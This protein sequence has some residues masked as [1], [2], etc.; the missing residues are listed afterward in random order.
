MVSTTLAATLIAASAF[1]EDKGAQKAP[2]MEMPK[3]PEQVAMAAKGMN[4]TWKCS[5]TMAASPMGPEH[6]YEATMT[7]KQSPDKYWL[8][9]NYAEKK[10]K[11][12]PMV[13]KFTEYRTFDAKMGKWVGAHIDEMGGMMTGTGTGDEKSEDWTWKAT[14]TPMMPGDFHFTTSMKSPKEVELKG[15]MMAP[16]GAKPVF[17]ATCKK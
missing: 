4:G 6:K 17:T 11:D 8:V 13:Y 9:G 12:H 16:D 2:A 10:S 3:P 5:G 1:A 15:E 14:T 7:W